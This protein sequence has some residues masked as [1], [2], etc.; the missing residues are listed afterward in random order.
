MLLKR[1]RINRLAE[2]DGRQAF[3]KIRAGRTNDGVLEHGRFSSSY[4]LCELLRPCLTSAISPAPSQSLPYA[5]PRDRRCGETIAP[6][7]SHR[8]ARACRAYRALPP[9]FSIERRTP[10]A[11]SQP[12][13]TKFRAT[14]CLCFSQF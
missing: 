10:A 4:D 13:Q 11:F 5:R 3:G 6:A 7:R 8:R 1:L 2:I 14:A 9:L 12:T